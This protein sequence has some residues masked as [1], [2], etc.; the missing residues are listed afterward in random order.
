MATF[1]ELWEADVDPKLKGLN[2]D[3]ADRVQQAQQAYRKQYGKD[4]PITSGFRTT[5]QQAQLASK[6]NPYPVAK[7]GTSLHETGDA[8]DI[9]KDVPNDFLAK[10]GLHRPLGAKDPV[11]TTLMPQKTA[12]FADLWEGSPEPTGEGQKAPSAQPSAQSQTAKTALETA[13]DLKKQLPGFL[14]S[15]ADVL[16]SAPSAIA[17]TVG[18]VVPRA[19]GGIARAIGGRPESQLTPEEITQGAQR[20]A[21]QL[22]Q[23]VGRAT[24]LAETE[25]YKQALPTKVMETVGQ[26][27][28][29][30]ADVI[31]KKTGIPVQ[32]VEQALNLLTVGLGVGVGKGVK[33]FKQA[34]AELTPVGQQMQAQLEAKQGKLGSVGAASSEAN[35]YANQITGE[36]KVRGQFPQVKLS[37]TPENVPVGEQQVRSQIVQ[38]ILGEGAPVRTGV[39]TGNENVLR[40]EYTKAKLPEPT[41]E[42]D[43]LKRQIANEQIA[44]SEYAKQR[45]EATGASPTLINEEQRGQRI[46]DVFHGQSPVDET[47]TSL[48]GYLNQSKKQ[49]YDSAYAKVGDNPIKSS[50]IDSFF[51]NPQQRATAET[52]GTLNV[53]DGAKKKIE[54]AKTVGFE[55]P[56]GKIAP[57]G[58]VAAFDAV[59]K[60]L[61]SIWSPERANAIRKINQAIDKDIASVADPALY[62]LGDKIHQI[63]KTIFSSK[64]IKSLFGEM[65]ANGVIKST[66][67]LEKITTKLNNLPK[68]QWRH[69]RDTLN[70]LANGRIR[71]VPEGVPAV[72]PELMQA[73]KSAVAE[74]DGALAREVYK[75]GASKVG[76]WNQNSANNV[77]N[78]VVGEKIL[79]TFPPSEIQKFHNLNYGGYL[80][81][82]IHQ[83]EGA[84][85]HVR[86]VQG[87][88]E[89]NLGKIG[90]TSGGAAGS[91]VG[92]PVGG[93]VGAYIGGQI[94]VKGAQKI[95]QRA[96]KKS[97]KQLEEEMKRNTELAKTKLSDIGK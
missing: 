3:L 78:S 62:K 36:E 39:I 33:A 74:I 86:R 6:P 37:K 58:S 8:I 30:R 13:F 61:N 20:V 5:E 4:L 89:G 34:K 52:E 47:P 88:I 66:T 11:H 60:S 18:Y 15:T 43:L 17:G 25:G 94:G 42:S 41:P 80:M 44:L 73:A 82:G 93:A 68:D 90:A 48:T 81:P 95:E 35:P 16:A 49:I 45:V 87:I 1:A 32:D 63:E 29:E 2:P 50:H 21:G 59:R 65:D 7:A 55:L 9:G 76:E 38:E 28:G 69:V 26:F 31:S 53:L 27:V 10:F 70:D 77:M 92:G 24:G 64:G 71:G 19:L 14:A 40:N 67:P 46:N 96:L 56:D 91:A 23:P 85:L 97:A 75:A 12:S 57:A 22:A 79:E 72:P 84:G 83:Y 51:D 54:L